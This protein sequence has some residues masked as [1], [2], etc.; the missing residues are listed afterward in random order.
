MRTAAPTWAGTLGLALRL[1]PEVVGVAE[2]TAV[3][4]GLALLS[5]AVV[6]KTRQQASAGPRGLRETARA[7]GEIGRAHV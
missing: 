5:P 3:E 7:L 1:A 6:E 4:E 2:A